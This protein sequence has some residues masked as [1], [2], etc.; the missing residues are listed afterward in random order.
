MEILPNPIRITVAI[1]NQTI[2]MGKK[3]VTFSSLVKVVTDDGDVRYERDWGVTP[4][5]FLGQTENIDFIQQQFEKKLSILGHA[6]KEDL[7]RLQ[8]L[9]IPFFHCA[10]TVAHKVGAVQYLK[11]LA[12]TPLCGPVPP[13]NTKGR[14]IMLTTLPTKNSSKRL[15]QGKK[16]GPY[17]RKEIPGRDSPEQRK[18][19]LM[20]RR[21]EL[22]VF[23]KY[24]AAIEKQP[25]KKL[26]SIL[27][28]EK[29]GLDAK[30]VIDLT[31]IDPSLFGED[32]DED[33]NRE[34]WSREDD[35]VEMQ[36]DQ[37]EE[38]ALF[39]TINDS[40]IR[41]VPAQLSRVSCNPP[42]E[43]PPSSTVMH[44]S[45]S[46]SKADATNDASRRKPDPEETLILTAGN[47]CVPSLRY[48]HILPTSTSGRTIPAE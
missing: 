30:P 29:N 1:K 47:S 24:Y 34:H 14:A 32:D 6:G 46:L 8:E 9:S 48:R 31:Y 37:S 16:S 13:P 21:Q 22:K 42:R 4:F 44:E 41:W 23:D 10:N 19:L 35:F 18:M 26:V 3:K 17:R 11:Q 25:V 20:T 39:E 5:D 12:E 43:D 7:E 15:K 28:S 40:S 2:T 33:D 38:Q 36:R 27:K 45:S